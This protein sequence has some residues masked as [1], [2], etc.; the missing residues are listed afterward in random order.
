ME[1]VKVSILTITYNQEKY[2]GQALESFVTQKTDFPFEAIVIDDNSTDG[3]PGIIREYA[4]KYPEIVK[5]VFRS[6]NVGP[7]ANYMDT[8]YRA[9]GEYIAICEGDDFF[10]DENKLQIQADYLD[11]HPEMSLCF[12]P[13][14]IFY[15]GRERE[16]KEFRPG[17]ISVE[18]LLKSNF[19]Q[20]NAV[21]YRRQKY[22]S[23]PVNI[24]PG[25]W[26]MHLYHAQFGGIGFVDRVMSAYRKHDQGIWWNA[27]RDPDEIYKKHG[28]AMFNMYAE[29]LKIYGGNPVYRDIIL[30]N[31]NALVKRLMRGD[32]KFGTELFRQA[33]GID[34]ER[35][36]LLSGLMYREILLDAGE[37][38]LRH[39]LANGVSRLLG[40]GKVY[41][42]VK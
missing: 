26:F 6:E 30:G 16:D 42:R 22:E 17:K 37:Y 32:K 34:E 39:K 23:L 31:L 27:R 19:I 10:T 28:A 8:F 12:H 40:L 24:M 20:T 33:L 2:I 41:R 9:A 25:D 29:A 13:V 18:E 14:K 4:A 5:P 11:A 15:Q 3:N 1:E 21:M 38:G 36:G 35:A 7:I